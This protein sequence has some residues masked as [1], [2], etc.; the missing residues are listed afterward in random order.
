MRHDDQSDKDPG[1]GVYG[2]SVASELSGAGPQTLRMYERKGLIDP[3]R[4]DGGTRRYSDDDLARVRRVTDLVDQ[5]VNLSGV[6]KIL[7]LEDDQADLQEHT[8]RVEADNARLRSDNAS[9]RKE[10]DRDD[11]DRSLPDDS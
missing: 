1:R 4:T 11:P 8:D 2:I 6:K 5:G 3:A 10:R 7:E 9:L